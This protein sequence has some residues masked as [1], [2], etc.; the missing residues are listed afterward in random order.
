[1]TGPEAEA[2]TQGGQ[3]QSASAAK[4]AA[5]I[6]RARPAAPVVLL[7]ILIALPFMVPSL[8]NLLILVGIFFIIVSG[9]NL[10]TGQTGQVSLGQTVF[11]ALGGYGTALLAIKLS[12]PTALGTLIMAIGSAAAAAVVGWGFLRLRGHYFALATL[13]LAVIIANLATGLVSFTGGPSGLTG[14]PTLTIGQYSFLG[15]R[16]FYFA[17]LAVAVAGSLFIRNLLRS[18][19]GR[20]LA[21]IAAD[22]EAASMLGVRAAT[23]KTRAFIVAAVYASVGGSL[24]AMYS[25][26]FSPNMISVTTAFVLVVML[27]L[28][29][30]RTIIGPLLGAFL[31]EAIPQFGGSAGLYEPL[32]AGLALILVMTYLPAGLWGGALQIVRRMPQR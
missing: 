26:F 9:L 5:V 1:M 2:V 8:T 22:Q 19:T 32:I 10:I 21:A 29:G 17:V 30:A 16:P 23:H 4:R 24:Y 13:G 15:S 20:A 3:L 11:V 6:Q 31:I 25:A 12:V 27:A 14:V 28:G 7:G 18:G